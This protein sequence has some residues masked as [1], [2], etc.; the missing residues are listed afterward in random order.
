MKITMEWAWEAMAHHLPSDP[1]VWDP[2]G[3]IAAVARHQND[4]V[5]VA[6]QP[7]PDI[8]W[9]AAA[10]LHTLAVC[11]PL[12]SPMNEFYAAAATRS[13]LRV[14]GAKSMPSPM[15]LGDLVEAAK[16]GRTDVFGVAR[17]LRTAMRPA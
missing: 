11:P 6:E 17:E 14:A 7:A 4:L 9:R 1:A 8:A 16:A 10:F 12:E 5:L 3:L 2:S 15:L 13:Y